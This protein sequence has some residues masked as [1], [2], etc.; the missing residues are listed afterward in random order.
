ML[1]SRGHQISIQDTKLSMA[2]ITMQYREIGMTHLVR[3]W[4]ISYPRT[5]HQKNNYFVN[6][7]IFCSFAWRSNICHTVLHYSPCFVILTKF[8]RI[9]NFVSGYHFSRVWHL[10]GIPWKNSNFEPYWKGAFLSFL[11]TSPHLSLP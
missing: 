7:N 5:K 4:N 9:P 8:F 3:C 11:S 1:V 2:G 10:D 6:I